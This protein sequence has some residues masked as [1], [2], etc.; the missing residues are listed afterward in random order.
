LFDTNLPVV[1]V[2]Y[3]F[4]S[5]FDKGIPVSI[6]IREYSILV[7]KASIISSSLSQQTPSQQAA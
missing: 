7:L 3:S 5:S 1:N 6:K 2:A 4:E